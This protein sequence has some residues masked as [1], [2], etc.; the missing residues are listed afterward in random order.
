MNTI[1]STEGLRLQ[2]FDILI[3]RMFRYDCVSV[4][5]YICIH[6]YASKHVHN[7]IYDSNKNAMAY[8][9]VCLKPQ[10]KPP[11]KGRTLLAVS[12]NG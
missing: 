9:P 4:H 11:W 12:N 8:K 2:N 10:E 6:L 5:A 1:S 3:T 7:Y